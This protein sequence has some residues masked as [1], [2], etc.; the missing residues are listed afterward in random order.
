M[1]YISW[2][3]CYRYRKISFFKYIW[4]AYSFL[5]ISFN[6]R[7]GKAADE[8]YKTIQEIDIHLSKEVYLENLYDINILLINTDKEEIQGIIYSK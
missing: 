6:R 7:N 8:I 1:Y 2:S 4:K 3:K 5:W